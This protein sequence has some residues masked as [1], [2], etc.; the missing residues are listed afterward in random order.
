MSQVLYKRGEFEKALEH[1]LAA[2]E[3]YLKL[4]EADN[5]AKSRGS[6]QPDRYSKDL[7]DAKDTLTKEERW[8]EA[9]PNQE[10]SPI[11]AI[12]RPTTT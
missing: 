9:D 2:E 3:G 7:Q 12:A 4:T 5:A 11:R 8:N 1:I 6:C 10:V